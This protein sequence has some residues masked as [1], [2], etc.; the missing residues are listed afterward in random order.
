MHGKRR[1]AGIALVR[2]HIHAVWDYHHEQQ[3]MHE[4]GPTNSGQNPAPHPQAYIG[5]AACP[6]GKH[7]ARIT[8]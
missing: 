8:G 4:Q 6:N 3:R 5:T 7:A 1:L 2:G